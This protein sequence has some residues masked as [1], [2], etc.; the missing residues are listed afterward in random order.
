MSTETTTDTGS[1]DIGT[2]GRQLTDMVV[3]NPVPSVLAAAATGA[4]LMALIALMARPGS[5]LPSLSELRAMAKDAVP[6]S[7]DKPDVGSLRGQLADLLERVSDALPS[8]SEAKSK[9]QNAGDAARDTAQSAREAAR[10]AA[11]SARD[12]ARDAAQTAR[13][14]AQSAWESVRDQAASVIDTVQPQISAATTAAT[15]VARENPLWAAVVAGAIGTL[16]GAQFLGK[17]YDR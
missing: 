12:T 10:D 3:A 13:D 17:L 16:I 5:R 8:K 14:T 2:A 15:K 6:G 4:G 1:F 9:I 7:I 11:L